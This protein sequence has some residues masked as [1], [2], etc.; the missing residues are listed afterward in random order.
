MKFLDKAGAQQ[1][2]N[3]AN[4]R[5]SALEAA[6]GGGLA[7]FHANVGDATEDLDNAGGR[8]FGKIVS[9]DLTEAMLLEAVNAGKQIILYLDGYTGRPEP[10]LL[11][12]ELQG[13]NEH[14]FGGI[15]Y[16]VEYPQR[17]L[18]ALD[19]YLYQRN[20]ANYQG[21][22]LG[23]AFSQFGKVTWDDVTDKPDIAPNYEVCVNDVGG[24]VVQIGTIKEGATQYNLYQ[25]YY[26]TDALANTNVKT[27][28]FANL[29]ADYSIND[30]IDATGITSNGI[31]IGNG[32]TDNDNRLIVQQFSKNNKNIQIRAYK[33]FS[34]ETALVKVIFK[35]N[36][37][38]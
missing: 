15:A 6:G 20:S 10:V 34:G 21:F 31:F 2:W 5:L 18:N 26:R 36:K 1:L 8:N 23:F 22:Y 12:H 19:V 4:A 37:N 16:V 17:W 27:H 25:F 9:P 28:S 38:A 29:L 33:D 7:I 24:N 32:R 13:G 11:T 14:R 30:F 35:G 3:A